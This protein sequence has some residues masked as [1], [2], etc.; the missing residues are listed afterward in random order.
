MNKPPHIIV[1]P[2]RPTQGTRAALAAI[3]R[4]QNL[5]CIVRDESADTIGAYLDDLTTA[6]HYALTVALAAMVPV[7]R[8]VDDLLAWLN[9]P[10]ARFTDAAA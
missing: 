10:L 4:A 1:P 6:Q 9:A 8:T 5:A 3:E 2:P 7:D